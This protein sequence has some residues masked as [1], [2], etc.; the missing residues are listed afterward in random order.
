MSQTLSFLSRIGYM[1]DSSLYKPTNLFKIGNLW[2]FPLHIM[3]SYIICKNKRWQNQSFEKVKDATKQKIDWA[4]VNRIKY[5]SILFHDRHF[6]DGFRLLKDWYLWL[7]TYLKD[8]QIK[9]ISYRD[10]IKEL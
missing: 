8:N 2:E 5:F 10:A 1:F 4:H 6:H 3:D 9:F 7:I